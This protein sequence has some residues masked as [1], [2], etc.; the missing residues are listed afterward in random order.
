MVQV[1]HSS[2]KLSELMSEQSKINVS[3]FLRQYEIEST[4]RS[5]ETGLKIYFTT[6]YPELQQELENKKIALEKELGR[7]LK[8]IPTEIAIEC[9][10][11]YSE[12]YLTEER[13]HRDDMMN[14]KETLKNKAPK[15]RRSRLNAVKI[16]LEDNSITF[17]KRFFKNL[18]G[19]S[20]EAVTDEHIPDNDELRRVIE[21]LPPIGKTLTLVLSSSGM[22]VNEALCL[23]LSDLEMTQE[24]V[25]VKIKA[26]YTKTRKKR[27]TYISPEAKQALDEWL[28]FRE[29]YVKNAN[30]RSHTNKRRESDKLFPLS[31]ANFNYMW[32]KALS[33][34]QLLKIDSRTNRIS[35]RLHNLRK[36]FRLRVG[37]YGQDES[38][39]LIGHQSG[40]NRVYANFNNGNGEDQ[41]REAYLKAIPDLS[42]YDRTITVT[43]VDED[44]KNLIDE[45]NH[46]VSLLERTNSILRDKVLILDAENVK[47][48]DIVARVTKIEMAFFQGK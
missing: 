32:K 22:R 25:K 39:A 11:K 21:Y 34:A 18:N 2:T 10:D 43:R 17:S 7:K 9:L 14:F 28:T 41:L 31:Q 23:E 15:T 42:I 24:P 5:Y 38:E 48:E 13:T 20:R 37:R 36:F 44:A 45:L 12:K 1:S 47:L 4:R 26:E 35:L 46:R 40:L 33:K 29:Q 8:H 6:I 16:Y 19:K 30:L 3:Q 27:I